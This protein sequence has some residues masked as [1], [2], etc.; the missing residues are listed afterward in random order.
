MQ[1]DYVELWP[2]VEK[3]RKLAEITDAEHWEPDVASGIRDAIKELERARRY[4]RVDVACT[5]RSNM[6][7]YPPEISGS[8]EFQADCAAACK[9]GLSAKLG[10]F[11]V[12]RGLATI[13]EDYRPN[14]TEAA[15]PRSWTL[16]AAFLVP[17]EPGFRPVG[18]SASE[19]EEM[20]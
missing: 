5:Q 14:V 20:T 13:A 11:A 8:P 19:K 18:G 10:P 2:L 16:R 15:I 7:L 12:E 17:V 1:K 4:R 6:D 9:R 3:L